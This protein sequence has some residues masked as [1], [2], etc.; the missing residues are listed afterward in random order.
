[1]NNSTDSIPTAQGDWANYEALASNLYAT[2]CTEVG[3]KAFNG[4]SLPD[5]P[6]F[7]A[8]PDKRVQSDAWVRVAGAVVHN[9]INRRLIVAI[10]A[11]QNPPAQERCRL[12][13]GTFPK[14]D[15]AGKAI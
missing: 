5:W 14:A 9:S 4:D 3:G 11:Q 13:E 8:D 12:P 2:Y 10:D 1:M 7:R 6:T 15:C